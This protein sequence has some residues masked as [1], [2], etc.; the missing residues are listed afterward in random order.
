MD[1]QQ[2]EKELND[3][4]REHESELF[5]FIPDA[6]QEFE[7]AHPG[8]DTNMVRVN[9]LSMADRKFMARAVAEVVSKYLK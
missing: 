7:E 9:A 2:L 8:I 4:M 5:E 6:I 1:A 3:W